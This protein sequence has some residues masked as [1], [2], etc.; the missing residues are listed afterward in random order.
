MD[1]TH[2]HVKIIVDRDRI[3][4][5]HNNRRNKTKLN[6]AQ[7]KST[8]VSQDPNGYWDPMELHLAKRIS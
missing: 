4:I 1:G 3:Q 5:I 8:A 7:A 2:T 6:Q